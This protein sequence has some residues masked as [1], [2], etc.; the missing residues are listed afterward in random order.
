MPLV[1]AVAVCG[2]F[3]VA[4]KSYF[5]RKMH[6]FEHEDNLAEVV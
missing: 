4:Y 5:G 3:F 1:R 6:I 2:S